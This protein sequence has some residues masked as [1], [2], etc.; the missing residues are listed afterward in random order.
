LCCI[1]VSP[2]IKAFHLEVG[3]GNCLEIKIIKGNKTTG[4]FK[5]KCFQ[6]DKTLHTSRKLFRTGSK[7]HNNLR[8]SLKLTKFSRPFT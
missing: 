5:T 8:K 1:E 6:G 4:F 2:D 3:M 7:Q